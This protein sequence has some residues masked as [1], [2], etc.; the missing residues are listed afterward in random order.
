MNIKFDFTETGGLPLDQDILN[1]LQNG[2]QLTE[3]IS[4]VLGSLVILSGC[5][6][7]G[8]NAG[9][10]VVAINGEVLPFVGG[11]ITAKV[12]IVQ[13]TAAL[14]YFDGIGRPSQIT[15]FATFGDD[16]VQNNLW[17]NFKSSAT[18]GILKRLERVEGLLRPFSGVGGMVWW[19]G[20]IADIPAGWREVEAMRG[21]FPMA[22]DPANPDFAIGN[23]AGD[24]DKIIVGQNNIQAFNVNLPTQPT[25]IP[26]SGPSTYVA[27]SQ[28]ST[29]PTTVAIGVDSPTGI[30]KMNPYLV[31]CWI[32][33]IPGTF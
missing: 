21:K 10:G 2:T 20:S 18:E 14:T 6:I 9:N 7:A 19:K 31:G 29:A 28:G 27:L 30:D 32:E 16:G 8:P 25:T 4:N 13:T 33:P 24:A 23:A 26:N 1:D 17:I 22:Y 5:V 3:K 12:I 11:T 15:R